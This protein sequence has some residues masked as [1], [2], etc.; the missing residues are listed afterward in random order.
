MSDS[1][2]LENYAPASPAALRD[3]RWLTAAIWGALLLALVVT[4]G[5]GITSFAQ[6]SI[7][8]RYI[9]LPLTGGSD[10]NQKV[11]AV[12]GIIM[13]AAAALLIF[14][15]WWSL[16]RATNTL[17]NAIANSSDAEDDVPAAA[18]WV[19]TRRDNM[20]FTVAG[21]VVQFLGAAWAV[22]VVTPAV[23]GLTTA[24]S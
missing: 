15:A 7:S 24:F 4:S 13:S 16:A 9:G 18:D 10:P 11:A 20:L 8:S 12:A 5:Y 1:P 17:V 6:G 23:L 22:M 21:E 2:E 3:A 19:A 14:A